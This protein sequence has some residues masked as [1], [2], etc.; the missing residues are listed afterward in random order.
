MTHRPAEDLA[1]ARERLRAEIREG[2][3]TLKDLR[4]EVREARRLIPRLVDDLVTAEVARQMTRLGDS[5]E[6]AM[7]AS[8]AKVTGEFDKLYGILTGQTPRDRRRRRMPLPELIR[9]LAELDEA[10]REE[11]HRG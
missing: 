8:V 11:D 2:R 3:E 1:E 9:I 6:K 10:R 4:R 7:E 5:T